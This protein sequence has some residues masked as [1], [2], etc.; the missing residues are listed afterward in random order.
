MNH[1]SSTYRLLLS[2]VEK[3]SFGFLKEDCVEEKKLFYDLLNLLKALLH[4]DL[5]VRLRSLEF[6]EFYVLS[7]TKLQVYF[8]TQFI[9]NILEI[10]VLLLS[11]RLSSFFFLLGCVFG[12]FRLDEQLNRLIGSL[13]DVDLVD[14]HFLIKFLF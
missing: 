12:G 5:S 6:L 9:L 1:G 2:F 4:I 14:D 8:L 13:N 11:V 7:L 3:N 10:Y